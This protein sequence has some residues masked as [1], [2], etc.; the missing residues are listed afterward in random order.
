M[1]LSVPETGYKTDEPQHTEA[2]LRRAI[3]ALLPPLPQGSRVLDIGC[4]NGYWVGQFLRMGCVAVGIDPSTE[5]IAIARR[6]YP[7]ARFEQALADDVLL[8]KLGERPFDLVISLIH[9]S[10]P[11]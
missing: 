3:M 11:T 2:Y 9:I 6:T 1:S 8:E 4:G 7:K 10:E 5:G